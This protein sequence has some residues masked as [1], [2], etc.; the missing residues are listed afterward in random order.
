MIPQLTSEIKGH[1]IPTA[2]CFAV[3]QVLSNM[4]QF[5]LAMFVSLFK[6]TLAEKM[7]T[8]DV[9]DRLARLKPVGHVSSLSG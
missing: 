8:A 7:K 1:A 6:A 3:W 5:S 4:Y 2:M 9:A